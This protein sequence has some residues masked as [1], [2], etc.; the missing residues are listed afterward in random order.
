MKKGNKIVKYIRSEDELVDI[1]KEN[2]KATFQ[3]F[4][5]LGE[6]NDSELEVTTIDPKTRTLLRVNV[7]DA[8]LVSELFEQLMGESVD[9]RKRF[10]EENSHKADVDI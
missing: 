9:D 10:I 4:K 1:K 7:E 2:P 6:M 5:G 3:R 8:H